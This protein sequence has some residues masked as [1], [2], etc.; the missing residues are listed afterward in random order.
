MSEQFSPARPRR[1]E[2]IKAGIAAGVTALVPWHGVRAELPPVARNRTMI[3]VWG[4]R[5]GRWVDWDLW[6]PYAIGANHQNG[7]NLIYEPLAFYSAFADK[8]YMWLAESYQY[9]PDF[10][11]LTIKTRSGINW[12]DGKPFSAE[13]VAYTFNSLQDLGAE[14]Q[15]GRR[16]PAVRRRTAKATDANTVVINFKVPAPRFFDFMAYKYDI[17]VYIVPKH[18]FEGQDWTTFTHFDLERTGRSP[19]APGRSSSPR[20]SR[21][22]STGATTGGRPRPAWHQMPKVERHRLAAQSSASSR[23]PRR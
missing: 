15:V 1:R 21:R 17:G 4:G 5:E 20:R 12:S 2:V 8:E 10:K 6:N 19:P 7:P 18:I 3:L 11:Q 9:S 16:R 14:G 23:L 13:D 22:S